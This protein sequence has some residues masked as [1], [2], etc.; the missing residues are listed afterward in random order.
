MGCGSSLG[1]A[2]KHQP[3]LTGVVPDADIDEDTPGPLWDDEMWDEVEH[4]ILWDTAP[5]SGPNPRVFLCVDVSEQQFDAE[6]DGRIEIELFAHVVPKTAENFRQ[7]CTGER[8]RHK[9]SGKM[10]SFE[11][12]KFHRIVPHCDPQLKHD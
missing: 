12:C 4:R 8:G 11:G 10:I 7:L 3:H 6:T 2:G 5:A 1:D 9:Q